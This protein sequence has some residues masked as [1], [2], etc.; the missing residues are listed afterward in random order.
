MNARSSVRIKARAARDPNDRQFY[1]DM[2]RRWLFLARVTNFLIGLP[3]CQ[4]R[5]VGDRA[6]HSQAGMTDSREPPI[7]N[8]LTSD[9]RDDF[10]AER[11][12]PP[13]ARRPGASFQRRDAAHRKYAEPTLT[14]STSIAA[15]CLAGDGG[16]TRLR[17]G[18]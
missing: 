15:D 6:G 14:Y 13:E 3:R 16:T 4:M 7:G 10:R 18:T 12:G 1:S 9:E 8:Q 11:P 17:E 5:S 2:E